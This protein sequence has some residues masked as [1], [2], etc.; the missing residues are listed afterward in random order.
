[1]TDTDI[2]EGVTL[3]WNKESLQFGKETGWYLLK[4]Q[5]HNH[6]LSENFEDLA[7]TSYNIF[8]VLTYTWAMLRL[9]GNLALDDYFSWGDPIPPPPMPKK[10]EISTYPLTVVNVDWIATTRE[11]H[12]MI[13]NTYINDL[14][15]LWESY[16]TMFWSDQYL[17]IARYLFETCKQYLLEYGLVEVL[18]VD[19]S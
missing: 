1:M 10:G 14:I 6:T 8:R 7:V 3:Y 19:A 9:N 4:M 12:L 17:E 18:L 11:N 5:A 16:P 2:I 13:V 15:H